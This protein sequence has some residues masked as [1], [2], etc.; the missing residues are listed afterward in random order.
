M[1]SWQQILERISMAMEFANVA[2]L[3]E[4]E[5]LLERRHGR[6]GKPVPVRYPWPGESAGGSADAG[7]ARHAG[8][9]GQRRFA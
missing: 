9:P 1:N 3:R 6:R 2:S 5:V 7:A 4:L 8:R